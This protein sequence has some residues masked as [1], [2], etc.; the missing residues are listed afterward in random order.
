MSN[1]IKFDQTSDGLSKE[2]IE[3]NRI[4]IK[5]F[6]S[7]FNDAQTLQQRIEIAKTISSVYNTSINAAQVTVNAI[8][9]SI[10]AR[11]SQLKFS[12]LLNDADY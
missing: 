12:G 10:D 7:D 5:K 2:A 6:L 8:K 11:E 1:V 4:L 3:S 9:V